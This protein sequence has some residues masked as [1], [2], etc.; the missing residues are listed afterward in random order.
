MG[1]KGHV[2]NRGPTELPVAPSSLERLN[3]V[4]TA[5]SA[6]PTLFPPEGPCEKT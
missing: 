4:R 3:R 2:G 1:A 6:T 5:F